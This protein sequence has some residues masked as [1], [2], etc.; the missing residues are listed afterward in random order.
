MNRR[1][2]QIVIIC[3][4]CIL[5]A[6][7]TIVFFRPQYRVPAGNRNETAV[8]V[9]QL[10]EEYVYF[11]GKRYVYN[12]NLINILF[13]GVDIS[14]E[15]SVRSVGQADTIILLSLDKHEKTVRFLQISRDAMVD[16][17]V[18][19]EA[20]YPYTTMKSQIT[21]Q[22]AYASGGR[23]S[24]WAMKQT[25][26]KLLYDLPINAYISLHTGGIAGINDAFGGVTVTVPED[27][28]DLDPA[29]VKGASVHLEGGLAQRYVRS[30]NID[31]SGSNQ[32]RMER[33]TSYLEAVSEQLNQMH[34]EGTLDYD[35]IYEAAK[36]YLITDIDPELIG[37][38]GEYDYMTDE[39]RFLPGEIKQGE[40]YEEFHVNDS[41]L[42]ADIISWFYQPVDNEVSGE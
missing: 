10:R 13:M 16:I 39:I 26:Q 5:L 36:P 27:Y 3:F 17:D 2:K 8:A 41:Q 18:Y 32:T 42:Q 9:D 31:T 25:V 11:Q 35:R 38:P 7:G 34:R 21:L 22:Y 29:F 4:G 28:T 20:G 30:R 33:Q 37:D 15:V 6:G 40:I 24:C 12:R 1:T 23:S 14:S 19:N